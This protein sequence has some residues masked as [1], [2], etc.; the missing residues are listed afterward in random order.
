MRDISAIGQ[1]T[2]NEISYLI[3]RWNW[4]SS[5]IY[6]IALWTLLQNF[7]ARCILSCAKRGRDQ[8]EG[9][10]KSTGRSKYSLKVKVRMLGVLTWSGFILF[11]V[12]CR[13]DL[14]MWW[15]VHSGMQGE[16]FT[17]YTYLFI[18]WR[19]LY[20]IVFNN[21]LDWLTEW[22]SDSVSEWVSGW[23]SE[24][25]NESELVGE[26]VS[27]CVRVSELVRVSGWLS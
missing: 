24:L 7:H 2:R 8:R 21:L 20:S 18:L 15:T 17:V 26:C 23:V 19:W 5:L 13:C 6:R 9:N 1:N 11:R 12:G 4:Y 14:L 3:L 27:E 16:T 10:L 25:V 22:V